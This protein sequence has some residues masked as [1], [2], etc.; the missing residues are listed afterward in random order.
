MIS[1]FLTTAILSFF[2]WGSTIC[3]YAQENIRVVGYF[4]KEDTCQQTKKT[5]DLFVLIKMFVADTVFQSTYIKED[6]SFMFK[7]RCPVKN[8]NLKYYYFQKEFIPTTQLTFQGNTA[9]VN[10]TFDLRQFADTVNIDAADLFKNFESYTMF[11][12]WISSVRISMAACKYGFRIN[13]GGCVVPPKGEQNYNEKTIMNL[14]KKLGDGWFDV[15][16]QEAKEKGY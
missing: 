5:A 11:G 3:C 7:K 16:W 8:F 6:G 10:T 15:F 14:N 1:K 12:L 4:N 2:I 9:V 13:Q